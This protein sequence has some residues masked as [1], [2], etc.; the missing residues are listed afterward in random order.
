[1]RAAI[2][3]VLAVIMAQ[4][5]LAVET[6]IPGYTVVDI[7]WDIEV[8]PGQREI[9]NGTVQEVYAQ[10]VELNPNFKINNPVALPSN[11]VERAL[12]TRS[13]IDRR[14]VN[15]NNWPLAER[16]RLQ[17]GI[18]YL[19]GVGGR[20]TNGPGPGN[21]GRVSCSWHAAIWWCND[22]SFQSFSL[23]VDTCRHYIHMTRSHLF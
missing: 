17:E 10:A 11:E 8:A 5:S 18:N 21:C 3:T 2:A 1:M 4:T 19:R 13:R 14:W 12:S 9:L 15:C 23:L 22:V 7:E 6:P 16:S 20:P